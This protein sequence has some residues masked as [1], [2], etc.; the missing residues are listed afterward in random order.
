MFDSLRKSELFGELSDDD[1][2]RL[3]LTTEYVG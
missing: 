2:Q 3:C 1:L